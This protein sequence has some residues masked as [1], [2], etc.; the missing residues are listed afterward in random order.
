MKQFPRLRIWALEDTPNIGDSELKNPVIKLSELK[1][2]G[3]PPTPRGVQD[4]VDGPNIPYFSGPAAG[5]EL[6]RAFYRFGKAQQSWT[7]APKYWE[8]FQQLSKL[9][10]QDFKLQ[11]NLR[12]LSAIWFALK[13]EDFK[14]SR[15]TW[16]NLRFYQRFVMFRCL[17]S[18]GRQDKT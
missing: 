1:V 9:K 13:F 7:V 6:F 8:S 12:I 16:Q 14:F 2:W 10:F 4:Q 11:P 18:R 15:A 3:G 5:Y 17:S